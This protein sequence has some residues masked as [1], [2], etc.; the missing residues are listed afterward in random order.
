MTT[1][2][3]VSFLT[4]DVNGKETTPTVVIDARRD[5]GVLALVE[6]YRNKAVACETEWS[7]EQDGSLVCAVTHD[8]YSFYV[9]FADNDVTALRGTEQFRFIPHPLVQEF[10]PL[11]LTALCTYL[12]TNAD[13]LSA[14]TQ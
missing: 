8:S 9:R 12:P 11:R 6:A 1:F 14:L 3:V 5:A 7:R 10:N 2:N 13:Q 4:H